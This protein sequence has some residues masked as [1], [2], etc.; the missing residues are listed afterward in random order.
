MAEFAVTIERIRGVVPIEGADRIEAA[1]VGDYHCVVA[2]GQFQT[3]DV[4]AYIPEQSIVPEWLLQ[5]MGLVGKLS[6]PQK[7]RVKAVKLKGTLSQG[8]VYPFKDVRRA[9]TRNGEVSPD[10]IIA[11]G[12][13]VADILGIVKYEPPTPESMKGKLTR[14][15]G[16]KSF[17]KYD[18]ENIKK[19]HSVIEEGTEVEL[20]E[21]IHGTLMQVA[22]WPD[23][24]EVAVSSKGLGAQGFAIEDN[25]QTRE[26]NVYIRTMHKYGLAVKIRLL[27][28]H[29]K[30]E[31]V[32]TG[33]VPVFIVGEVFGKGIQDLDYGSELTF[34]VFDIYVGQQGCGVY[35]NPWQR[36]LYLSLIG[37][38]S[39][40]VL[41]EGP[42]SK[43][44]LDSMTRGKETV[45]GTDKHLREGVVIRPV[46]NTYHPRLGRVVLKS[47]SEEYLLRKGGTEFN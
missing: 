27:L 31:A 3:G 24:D 43:Q 2:K 34:R 23:T 21:K 13:D 17:L 30:A 11:E 4:V 16:D 14:P 22:Y 6:G 39:V 47:V 1:Q 45:S 15:R 32:V 41:F 5:E 18:V 38:E 36:R 12:D 7:N 35:L 19:W 44:L 8:L 29:L 40:P 37:L 33:D 26:N 42:F 25:E 46:V 9:L 10:R 28:R 20:T